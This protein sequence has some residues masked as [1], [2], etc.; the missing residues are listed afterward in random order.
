MNKI[1]FTLHA[2]L[3]L[4]ILNGCGTVREKNAD[5]SGAVQT[6]KVILPTTYDEVNSVVNRAKNQMK[7]NPAQ[8]L[9]TM[10]R[11]LAAHQTLD[12]RQ[13]N[14]FYPQLLVSARAVSQ[15]EFRKELAKIRAWKENGLKKSVRQNIIHALCEDFPS[16]AE[17]LLREEARNLDA[18]QILRVYQQLAGQALWTRADEKEFLRFFELAGSVGSGDRKLAP[19]QKK[20]LQANIG[21][22]RLNMVGEYV[23]YDAA[24][25]EKFIAARKKLFNAADECVIRKHFILAALEQKNRPLYDTEMAK[26]RKLPDSRQKYYAMLDIARSLCRFS[27]PAAEK[28]RTELLSKKLDP[29]IRYSVMALCMDLYPAQGFNYRFNE[30]GLYR[31][32]KSAAQETLQFAAQHKIDNTSVKSFRINTLRKAMD[33]DDMVFA[34]ELAGKIRQFSGKD[35]GR[36]LLLAEYFLR[37]GNSAQACET[38]AGIGRDFPAER[39]FTDDMLFFLKGG[40]PVKFGSTPETKCLTDVERMTRLR[41]V[42]TFLFRALRYDEVRAIQKEVRENMFAPVQKKIYTVKFDANAPKTADAW[43]RME[44][45]RD[46]NGMETRFERYDNGYEISRTTD[47]TRHLRSSPVLSAPEEY[48]TGLYAVCDA[49]GLHLFI[50]GDDPEIGEVVLGKRDAGGLEL[51]MRPGE[52]EV[53]HSWY[54]NELPRTLDPWD[55]NWS[56]P[57]RDY[58]LTYDYMTK[59]AITTPEGIAAHTFIPWYMFYDKLPVNGNNWYFGMQF[60]R[61]KVSLTLSGNVHEQS[62]MLELRFD[63]TPAQINALRRNMAIRAFNAYNTLRQNKGE[64]IL[65]W[66]DGQLGDPRFFKQEVEPLI[67]KLDQAGRKL[68]ESPNLPDE[69]Y[70]EFTPQWAEIKY[71]IAEKRARYLKQ[72]LFAEP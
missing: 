56:A 54:M 26:L 59:D 33:F 43:S 42:S 52:K 16:E 50:R 62:R 66:N 67:A 11:F 57:T 30:P 21:S 34:D 14:R 55:V 68:F 13:S 39:K 53:Y 12:E 32:F 48:R 5:P 31:K 28:M 3:A 65:T 15:D 29:S 64:F 4:L 63:L 25:A 17:A 10:R 2:A 22:V 38:L 46:W 8:V 71:V 24:K 51:S 6:A 7:N 45:Y 23:K 1:S 37:R 9:D 49:E 61:R 35:K 27:R 20:N 40:T 36:D 58:R 72:S 60:W 41:Q 18:G 19:R 69:F 70:A 47:A 44:S